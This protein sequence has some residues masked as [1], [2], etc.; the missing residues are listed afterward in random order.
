[1]SE[2]L[3]FVYHSGI[4]TSFVKSARHSLCWFGGPLEEDVTGASLPKPLHHVATLH[5]SQ[6]SGHGA[7]RNAWKL[8]LIHGLFYDGGSLR[9]NFQNRQRIDITSSS[10]GEPTPNWP[11]RGYPELLPFVPL[12]A[13]PITQESWKAFCER[14]PNLPV[15][16]PN[17]M[18]VLVPPPA[19][20]GFSMW[21]RTGDAEGVTLV[22]EC[23]LGNQVVNTYNVCG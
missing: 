19:T 23:D 14:V 16:Q 20:I 7:P 15:E 1:M 8:P 6:F 18:V 13:G 12:E 10:L 5:L 17:E 2:E 22:F 4:T 9:Y 11:Y 21:G 3:V